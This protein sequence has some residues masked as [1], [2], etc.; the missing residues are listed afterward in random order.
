M[1][2]RHETKTP[3]PCWFDF[4]MAQACGKLSGK[5]FQEL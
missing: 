3:M 2:G 4:Q 5:M 1:A